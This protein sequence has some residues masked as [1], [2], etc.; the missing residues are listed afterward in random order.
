MK[1]I[2]VFIL[3]LCIAII[4][5]ACSNNGGD[6]PVK[7]ANYTFNEKPKSIVC[8]NDSI[9]DI[10]IACGY[11][12]RITARSDECT[13]EELSEVPS[14]GTRSR[15]NSQKILDVNPDVVFADKSLAEET[16]EKIEKSQIKVMTMA[17]AS[18]ADELKTLYQNL[19]A[20]V[21][22]NNTGRENG[23]NKSDNIL[24]MLT[25]LQR[26]VPEKEVQATACYIYD[27]EGNSASNDTFAGKLFDYAN[28][29][30]VCSS[31][32]AG[33]DMLEIIKL[34]NPQYIFCAIGLKEKL[35]SDDEL[36][37]LSAVKNGNVFEINAME[38]Q[39]QGNSMTEVVTYIIES[40]YPEL[41]DSES[42]VEESSKEES[43]KEESIIEVKA[44]NSLEITEDMNFVLGEESD[45]I[46]K[47]QN[48]LK[49]LGYFSEDS[50]GYFGELSVNAF[51]SFEKTNGLEVDGEAS[52]QDLKLLF[53]A[54][55][56]PKGYSENSKQ[57]SSKQ[58][59][60]KQENSKQESSKQESSKQESSKRESS[61]QE[62]SKQENSKQES[63]KQENSNQEKIKVEA[64]NSLK[65][66]E[67]TAFGM[68][69]NSDDF[70]KVQKRLKALGFFNDDETGY[71]G[72][73]S[74]KAFKD[75]EKA[76][77]LDQDGFA[78]S[79]DLTLLFSADAKAAR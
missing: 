9:A 5:T 25:D 11:A 71:F 32:L 16:R 61:K 18:T 59:S 1:R 6:Y 69:D 4:P 40:M 38:F 42:S 23:K 10:L 34:S 53:S 45:D 2:F 76:N 78:S 56:K 66:T 73:V 72:E 74:L 67:D 46:K 64:D 54:D 63:S 8:L 14:V 79:E 15:P 3:A 36:K 65:I 44:D 35:L 21:D 7:I 13:Q 31:Q 26:L 24:M 39:R 70:K 17:N 12:D 55:A 60:S 48:R 68:G 75:F 28:A 30:N 29:I 50:T 52:Y 47:I 57:E 62:S 22:G 49:A 33:K 27:I 41:K 51:M 37:N 43:S 20:I 19:C 77:G 58:E